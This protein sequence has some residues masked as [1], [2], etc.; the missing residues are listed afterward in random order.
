MSNQLEAAPAHA[1]EKWIVFLLAI[2]NFTHIVDFVVMAP[3]N[4]F[5]KEALSIN[6]SE[7]GL[8][9]SSYTFSA[10]IAGLI[11]FFKFDAYDRRS[12]LLFLYAGFI[13]GNL[14]CAVAPGYKFFLMSRV[15]A[16][17]FGGVL[18]VLVFSVI[19]DII[20]PARR[21]KTTGIVMA[22]FSAASV[23]GIPIGLILAKSFD[24]HA[25][26]TFLTVLSL[27]VYVLIWIKFPSLTAHK[28]HA[29]KENDRKQLLHSFAT[30]A[31]VRYALLLTF[32]LMVAGF[33]VVPFISDYLVFN[34][35]LNKED[36]L[37]TYF[38]GGLATAVSGPLVGKLADVYGKQKVFVTA[39]LISI[40]PIYL[41]T[42]LPPLS[43]WFVVPC[44]T[45]FFI[46]FGS[47]FVPA[48]TLVTS[49]V[50]PRER[51][52]FMSINSTVQQFAS[53]VAV[54]S[55]GLIIFNAPDGRMEYF[56]VCGAIAV[57]FTF[58]SIAISYKVKEV[59]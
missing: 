24:F 53:S 47:R 41:I 18:G 7:F 46:C 11:A 28:T 4:P 42:V 15:L 50:N 59:S 2:I 17:A 9:V 19:G 23:L 45:V 22:A 10:A 39:A 44:T 16:G 33:T 35:G 29:S 5:L 14:L 36:L 56:W 58:L 34:V 54:M 43:L 55:S 1:D 31:N 51:G 26:F 40:V 6:S 37:Y 25:P 48:M 12:A 3:L 49:A 27:I 13:L 32:C 21:G 30:N 8:L 20:P 57:C 38:F 52:S